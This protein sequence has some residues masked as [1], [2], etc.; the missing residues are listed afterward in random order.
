MGQNV[1]MSR[2][3]HHAAMFAQTSYESARGSHH[4]VN[5]VFLIAK[6]AFNFSE[7]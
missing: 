7:K 3:S 1:Y 5:F 2:L 6:I 4:T